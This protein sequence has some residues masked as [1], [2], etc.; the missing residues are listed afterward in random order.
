MM[1]GI[2]FFV[3]L[4]C[5]LFVISYSIVA[6]WSVVWK[7]S[8]GSLS[9]LY[10][11]GGFSQKTVWN[12]LADLGSWLHDLW[13][14]SGSSRVW[15]LSFTNIDSEVKLRP[16][17]EATFP[18]DDLCLVF[19]REHGP[20]LRINLMSLLPIAL[21]VVT[22]RLKLIHIR[23]YA[24]FRLAWHVRVSAWVRSLLVMRSA[25]SVPLHLSHLSHGRI[26]LF[27]SLLS[28]SLVVS[29]VE[30]LRVVGGDPRCV[31]FR[32]FHLL[33]GWC[34]LSLTAL[35]ALFCGWTVFHVL[36]RAHNIE[37]LVDFDRAV[38]VEPKVSI[39]VG[40]T[41]SLVLNQLIKRASA[42]V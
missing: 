24:S 16:L 28:E 39:R 13:G 40:D 23:A 8:N 17:H 20:A 35:L 6:V 34:A 22:L 19:D 12:I 31:W 25:W 33:R 21:V 1:A 32:H 42:E 38:A 9:A 15:N 2:Y 30:G 3:Y 14:L 27:S 37:L 10:T 5:K 29:I 26:M 11:S 18:L 7:F 36:K 41:L 4:L